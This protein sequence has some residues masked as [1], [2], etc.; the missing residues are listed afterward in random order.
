MAQRRLCCANRGA[1]YSVSTSVYDPRKEIFGS[2]YVQSIDNTLDFNLLPWEDACPLGYETVLARNAN[3][4]VV[5]RCVYVTTPYPTWYR[6]YDIWKEKVLTE[7]A[8]DDQYPEAGLPVGRANAV[9]L[10][11][12]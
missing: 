7:L 1:N 8:K 6:G 12:K 5:R 2:E 3:G 4:D 11:K 10:R 9:A